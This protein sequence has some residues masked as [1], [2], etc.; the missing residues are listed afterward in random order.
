MKIVVYYQKKLQNG[1]IT[2]VK[3]HRY[4]SSPDTA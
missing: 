4:G 3:N 1:G 2:N